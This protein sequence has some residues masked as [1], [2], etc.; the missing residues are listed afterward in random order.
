M[1]TSF[2]RKLEQFP[3]VEP[4]SSVVTIGTFDGIHRGHQAI[5]RRVRMAA[6][7]KE[8]RSVLVTFQPHPRMVVSPDN[9]PML[10]TSIEEKE[11]FVPDFFDGQ[12][13]V[14]EF[15]KQLMNQTAEDFVKK[16]LVDRIG[17]SHLIVGYDHGL[18]KNRSGDTT[19]LR[20]MGAQWVFDVDVVEPVHYHGG[21]VSSSRIRTAMNEG[22]YAEAIELLGHEYAVYGTVE[23][24]IGLGHKLGYPTANI[25][26]SH[27][28][29]LP[30]QGV[31]ACWVLLD[32]EEKEGMLFIGQNHFNPVAGVT[33]EANLFDFDRD[34]YDEE[35]I[36]Y[37]TQFIRPNQRFDSTEK[38]VA[39]I[40][41]DK[42]NVLSILRKGV[43]P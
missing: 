42:K 35:V 32:G 43:K 7:E 17:M 8:L 11:Q 37:P 29:L 34:I 30:P 26:Y 2:L 3:E 24:G 36:V 40:E 27:R 31:Y 10:L 19:Q 41:E 18:G 1:T 4:K 5:L 20:K 15:N 6:A 39:Q 28:K 9:V 16:V 21:P 13:L 23:R 33:V 12:V 38:L 22:R 14:L 25:R